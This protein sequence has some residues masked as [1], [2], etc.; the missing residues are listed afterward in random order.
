MSEQHEHFAEERQKLQETIAL[1]EKRLSAMK[2][3]R[4]YGDDPALQALDYQ[5]E[6]RRRNLMSA[7]LE[8][9]F[10]RLDF[11][12][13][14]TEAAVPYYIG[15]RGVDNE[16]NSQLIVVDWRAPVASMFY[17]FTGGDGPG[18]YTAPDGEVSGDV[19]LKRNFAIRKQ[20]L[21]RV[22]DSY[23]KGGD[24]LGVA[25]DYLLYRLGENKDNRL[26]DIVSTIQEEQDRIIR[27]PK[28]MA[29]V[30]QG[31]A[32]SGKTTVALHRLAYLIY[33]YRE[34]IRADK[35]IIFAPNR[36]FIDYISDVLPELGVGEIQ[37]TTFAEWASA[38]LGV[39]L[40]GD[41]VAR[42]FQ[43][44]ERKTTAAKAASVNEELP[45]L[46]KGSLRFM[47]WL[48]RCLS[49]YETACVP[50]EDFEA[51]ETAKL[52]LKTI[53][54]WYDNE[55]KHYPVAKRRQRVVARIERW[56]R[57]ELER[58]S[59]PKRRKAFKTKSGQRLR[60]YL[61]GWPDLSAVDLYKQLLNRKSFPAFLPASWLEEL[62]ADVAYSLYPEDLS[63]LVLIHSRINGKDS[64]QFFDHTV[65]DEAQD[66][67]PFQ[68]AVLRQFTKSDSF[69]ILGDLSQGIHVHYGIHDWAQFLDMFDQEQ[70]AFFKLNRSY[71]STMEIIRFANDV[72][73]SVG[74]PITLAEPVFRSGEPV[75]VIRVE[76]RDRLGTIESAV[77][78]LRE[79][80]MN[81]I[82]VIGRTE[83]DCV[84]VYEYLENQGHAATLLTVER[85]EYR[86]GVSVLPVYLSKGFEF[87]AV[88]LIDVDT[89]RYGESEMEAKLLYVGCTRALHKLVLHHT[90]EASPLIQSIRQE[91]V[92]SGSDA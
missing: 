16:E 12:E 84:P 83:A 51:W 52:P 28:G 58:V 65:I 79:S 88:L 23:V 3:E 33:Q 6:M 73:S 21:Q 64:A 34:T 92:G 86:G 76:E 85:N 78:A 38:L 87:D 80:G 68:L 61:K 53:R 89:Q 27:S 17:S 91:P 77:R 44:F 39:K 42:Q 57:M 56:I 36:M 41:S 35:M 54:E 63:P 60:A 22:V 13:E 69:T 10:A 8:P 67:S 71:R 55:Y 37:Q 31:V 4:Y 82:A 30:I 7:S 47:G 59:D 20:E 11:H 90:V 25:D 19:L 2:T 18:T 45:T 32:G 81:T 9:Y 43:W 24:N 46:Y 50:T 49:R 66:Y 40:S 62:P 29:L 5:Q 72:I 48:D 70:T 1:I 15:K 14:G 74:E 26:R 75:D